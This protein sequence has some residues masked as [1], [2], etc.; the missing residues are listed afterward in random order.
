MLGIWK[1]QVNFVP[2][3]LNGSDRKCGLVT[4]ENR[5]EEAVGWRDVWNL[6]LS[7]CDL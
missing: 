4:T 5:W 7:C 1:C 3:Q 2:D 6:L